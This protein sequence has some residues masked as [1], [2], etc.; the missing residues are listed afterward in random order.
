MMNKIIMSVWIT[1][2]LDTHQGRYLQLKLIRRLGFIF[3]KRGLTEG[4]VTAMVLSS[5]INMLA[6]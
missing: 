4:T 2:R 5:R 6:G 3:F 1:K